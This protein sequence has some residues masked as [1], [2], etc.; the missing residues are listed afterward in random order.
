MSVSQ[1]RRKTLTSRH[2]VAWRGRRYAGP[3]PV[4]SGSGL[5]GIVAST[6]PPML[7]TYRV[8]TATARH[9]RAARAES[10]IR[11]RCHGQPARLVNLKPCAI[12]ARRPYQSASLA[13]GGRSVRITHGS[14]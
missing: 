14:L 3:N 8:A 6:A 12:Q 7:T 10:V 4:T 13:S 1:P 11:V 5:S 9:R 2:C